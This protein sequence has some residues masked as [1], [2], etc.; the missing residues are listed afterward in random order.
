MTK[1]QQINKRTSLRIAAI[2]A[3]YQYYFLKEEENI[4]DIVSDLDEFYLESTKP[5]QE[6]KFFNMLITTYF[7]NSEKVDKTIKDS[8]KEKNSF[9]KLP[10][11]LLQIIRLAVV[12]L[13]F[14]QD[15]SVNIILDEYVNLGSQFCSNEKHVNFVNGL[16]D[17]ISK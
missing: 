5:I 17:K 14:I 10:N 11:I 8:L 12:E 4:N 2:Q 1:T 13:K 6:N 3:L 16:L 15:V 7:E 9:E